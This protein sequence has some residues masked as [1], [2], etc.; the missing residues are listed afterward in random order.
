MKIHYLRN[1]HSRKPFGCQVTLSDGRSGISLCNPKDTF[2]KKFG[3]RIAEGRALKSEPG[4]I[5]LPPIESD[6][7]MKKLE[8]TIWFPK[9]LPSGE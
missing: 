5:L 7:L 1:V 8:E 2:N 4:V 3:R 6:K 9:E